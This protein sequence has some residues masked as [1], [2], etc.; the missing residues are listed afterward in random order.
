MTQQKKR[1][2]LMYPYDFGSP[3]AAIELIQDTTI[4]TSDF[5][6]FYFTIII[7]RPQ[8]YFNDYF[9]YIFSLKRN[10]SSFV[11][12]NFDSND[13]YYDYLPKDYYTK[14]PDPEPNI[15]P[16]AWTQEGIASYAVWEDSSDNR[17]NIFGLKRIDPFGDVNDPNTVVRNFVLLQNYPNPFNPTTKISWRS[18]ISSWQT[19]KVYD[20]L[21]KEVKTLVDEIRPAGNYEVDF[22]GAD[23]PSGVYFYQLKAGNYIET[24]KM[25][26]M[27]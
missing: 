8:A 11:R 23:L 22:D 27:K 26:L 4:E 7:D 25:I 3:N 9:P 5:E 15:G 17:I 2:F 12:T 16:L 14:V 21:G 1:N 19:L 6:S 18:P 24:K 13:Y 20:I 10:D